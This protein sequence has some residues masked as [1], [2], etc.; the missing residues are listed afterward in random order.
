MFITE[1]D[2]ADEE[3]LASQTKR[4][5]RWGSTLKGMR[6]YDLTFIIQ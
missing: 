2:S 3:R 6:C 4:G 5:S 1:G